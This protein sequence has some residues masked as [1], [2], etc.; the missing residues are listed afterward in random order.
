MR[1][2]GLGKMPML[3]FRAF[4]VY[5]TH[6]ANVLLRVS[7]SVDSPQRSLGDEQRV[8]HAAYHLVSFTHAC[9][10]WKAWEKGPRGA[11]KGGGSVQPEI[12]APPTSSGAIRRAESQPLVVQSYLCGSAC[13]E[14]VTR[15]PGTPSA[16]CFPA[17]WHTKG[18]GLKGLKPQSHSAKL[19]KGEEGGGEAA[20]PPPPSP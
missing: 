15:R 16:A 3:P 13:V 20:P 11:K 4:D 19:K 6:T 10:E 7:T 14:N 18:P 1:Q 9:A 2:R 5:Q 8:W 12:A 17:R